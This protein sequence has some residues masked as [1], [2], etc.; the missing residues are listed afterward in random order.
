ME[1]QPTAQ[2]IENALISHFREF[3]CT[4]HESIIRASLR[5]YGRARRDEGLRDAKMACDAVEEA[6][7]DTKNKIARYAAESGV[8]VCGR[9]L[10]ELLKADLVEDKAVATEG[11][12]K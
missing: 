4:L 11:G 6:L 9:M 3:G 8:R 2:E 7:L 12:V 5:A 10:D 1:K